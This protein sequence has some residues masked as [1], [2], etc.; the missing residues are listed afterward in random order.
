MSPIPWRAAKPSPWSIGTSSPRTS[1]PPPP[2]PARAGSG[3][4]ADR[5]ASPPARLTRPRGTSREDVGRLQSARSAWQ[6]LAVMQRVG[7]L[8]LAQTRAVVA[9]DQQRDSAAR[10]DVTSPRERVVER[11]ELLVQEPILLQ[12]RNAL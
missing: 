10:I 9:L 3:S 1:T 2:S 4:S 5:I 6:R 7:D 12:R 11:I 8:P